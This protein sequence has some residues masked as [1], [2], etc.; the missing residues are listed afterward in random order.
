MIVVGAIVGWYGEDVAVDDLEVGQC[1]ELDVDAT[2][3]T[4]LPVVD[5]DEAHQGEVFFVD[6]GRGRRRRS[7][8]TRTDRRHASASEACAG[9]A[10]LED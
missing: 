8:A 4:T 1:V 5:C 10:V 7:P 9:D 6:D 2:E 3:M